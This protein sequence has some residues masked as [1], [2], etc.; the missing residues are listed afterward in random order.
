M[1]GKFREPSKKAFRAVENSETRASGL[2]TFSPGPR[3]A[4]QAEKLPAGG[5]GACRS[6]IEQ[7]Q[8]RRAGRSAQG[9]RLVPRMAASSLE[10]Q[11]LCTFKLVNIQ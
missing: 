2:Q 4:L 11:W 5:L 9:R 10:P 6:F 3:E 7:A 1:K 8:E